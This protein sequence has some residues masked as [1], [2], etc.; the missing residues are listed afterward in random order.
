[1]RGSTHAWEQ[2]E[3]DSVANGK[4][5]GGTPS[6]ANSSLWNGTL[7]WLQSSDLVE[8]QV[9]EVQLNKHIS[10]K[11]LSMTAARLIPE[12]SIA[13]VTRVGVGK[14]A[15]MPFSYSTSQDFLSLSDLRED[16]LFL[17]YSIYVLLKRAQSLLQGTS[18]KGITKEELLSKKI[19]IPSLPEQRAIGSFFSRLDALIALHQREPISTKKGAHDGSKSR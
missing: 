9:L 7:P 15:Y 19:V 14:L 1:M 18:I 5:G 11:A 3:L 2:R 6:T 12:K 13:V 17:S 16:G 4:T 8:D 10:K